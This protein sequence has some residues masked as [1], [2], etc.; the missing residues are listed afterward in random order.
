MPGSVEDLL[1]EVQAV[2]ADL[3]LLP[4]AAGGHFA[5]FQRRPWFAA[6]PGCL[7]CDVPP[8]VA[9]KHSE[10]VVV[11][12]R[13]DGTDRTERRGRGGYGGEGLGQS[14]VNDDVYVSTNI[15]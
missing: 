7:Q 12:A 9:V 13:H 3:V 2:H 14:S 11:R 5:R 10:E 1:V 4:L 8:G 15:V 6:L